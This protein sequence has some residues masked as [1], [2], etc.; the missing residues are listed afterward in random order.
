MIL[1]FQKVREFVA[2]MTKVVKKKKHLVSELVIKNAVR[3]KLINKKLVFGCVSINVWLV[4][5]LNLII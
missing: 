3:N 5:E 2:S 1:R 4:L